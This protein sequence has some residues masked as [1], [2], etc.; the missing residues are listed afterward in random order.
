MLKWV[1]HIVKL[2]GK[3]PDYL[4]ELG[5]RFFKDAHPVE[6]RSLDQKVR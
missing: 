3:E 4:D 1:G 2:D 5:T 6:Y